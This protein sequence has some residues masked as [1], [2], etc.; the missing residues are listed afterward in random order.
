MRRTPIR[1]LLVAATLIAGLACLRSADADVV[2]LADQDDV[3][4]PSRVERILAA[5]GDLLFHD[6]L[7]PHLAAY[8]SNASDAKQQ[9]F[10]I[11]LHATLNAPKHPIRN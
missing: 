9:E 3:W 1:V 7:I 6:A 11:N 8:D 5:G 2:F 4:H 10:L